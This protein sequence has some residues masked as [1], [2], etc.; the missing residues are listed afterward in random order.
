MKQKV[1]LVLSGGGSK[2]LA[3]IGAINILEKNGF[4]IT[5][6]AG[7]SIGSVIGGLYAMGRM[8]EYA[9]WIKSLNK[10]SIWGLM[11]FTLSKKGLVKGE[12][13]FEQMKAFI[14]DMMIEEMKIPFAA[15]ATDVLNEKEVV[16]TTGSFY[17]AIRASVAIPTIFIPVKQ[18]DIILVD[19]GV[20]SPVPIEFVKRNPGDIL[21]VVNLYAPVDE[22]NDIQLIPETPE[23]EDE[24]ET[25]LDKLSRWLISGDKKDVS[26]FDLL[27]AT[28]SCMVHKMAQQTIDK[29]KPDILVNI[30]HD[31]ANAFDFHKSDILIQMGAQQAQKAINKYQLSKINQG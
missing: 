27:S 29:Y 2:G 5:S 9:D 7:T 15:V 24:P 23:P 20:L 1:A 6:I 10:K 16:F 14:P 31:A 11:D 8:Q 28:T 13:V 22:N 21:V 12:R 17:S 26:Y 4:E 19:G 30:P 3:H 18:D 25:F